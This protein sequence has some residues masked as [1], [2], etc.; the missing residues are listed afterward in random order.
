M[1]LLVCKPHQHCHHQLT[2]NNAK[3]NKLQDSLTSSRAVAERL[4]N[5]SCLSLSVNS[6]IRQAQS[7]IISRTSASDLRLHKLNS[8]L[9]SSVQRIH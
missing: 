8:V 5:A 3:N 6:T 7:S 9:F 2:P 1:H 4:C